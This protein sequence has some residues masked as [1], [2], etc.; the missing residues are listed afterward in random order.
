LLNLP[1]EMIIEICR[2]LCLHCRHE[3]IGELPEEDVA[4]GIQDQLAISR[5]SRCSKTLRD[6]AQPILFHFF[7]RLAQRASQKRLPAFVHTLL[8][9]PDLASSVRSLA[10]WSP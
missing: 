8:W 7:A 6:I 5:L 3:R 10:L 4:A 1:N 2:S 9:R